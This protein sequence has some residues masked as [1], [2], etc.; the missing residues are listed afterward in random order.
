MI[1]LRC[2][3]ASRW[4]GALLLGLLAVG[5]SQAATYLLPAEGD[6]IGELHYTRAKASDTLLD[7]ARR[8]DVG[9]NAIK[10]ANPQVDPWM[11]G[12]GTKILVPTRHILPTAPREGIVINLAEMRLY[13]YNTEPEE[14][15]PL[16]ST[17]PISIGREGWSTPVGSYTI[18]KRLRNPSWAVPDSIKREWRA[19][20]LPVRDT[21]PPGPDNPLGEYAMA[22]GGSGYLIHGTNRPFSIGMKVSHGCVRLYPED[23]ELLINRTAKGTPVRIVN[24]SLKYGE[25]NGLFY[26]EIH[27]PADEQGKLDAIAVVNKLS[28]ILPER[29]DS[30]E[31]ARLRRVATRALGVAMPVLQR[32]E[33]KPARRG[34]MLQVASYNDIDRART[35]QLRVERMDVPVAMRGCDGDGL[36]RV[37]VGPFYDREYMNSVA[38]R[39]KWIT[40]QKARVVPYRPAPVTLSGVSHLAAADQAP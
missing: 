30:A 18:T 3:L 21:V 38:K 32:G 31:W 14:G 11:P 2:R 35:M 6:V 8:F 34:W 1:Q 10:A 26:M 9:F 15:P 23:I 24:E 22:L 12:R 29:M 5:S 28:R 20:G 37:E 17:F 40:R 27:K 16:V 36:C 39:I 7:I 25:R 13:H 33:V 19:Q 4:S